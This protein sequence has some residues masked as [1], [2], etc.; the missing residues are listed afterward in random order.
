MEGWGEAQW[1]G[2]LGRGEVGTPVTY[3]HVQVLVELAELPLFPGPLANS[4]YS[5]GSSSLDVS[6]SRRDIGCEFHPIFLLLAECS[7]MDS[8]QVFMRQLPV[9][10]GYKGKWCGEW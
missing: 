5:Q 8:P 10:P 4:R 7:A 2:T 1:A 9:T 3:I 6:S